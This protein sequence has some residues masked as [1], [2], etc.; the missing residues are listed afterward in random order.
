ML[1]CKGPMLLAQVALTAAEKLAQLLPFAV[2][3]K[4]PSL[5]FTAYTESKP[6]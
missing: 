5:V 4:L 2:A 1:N 3:I 6:K